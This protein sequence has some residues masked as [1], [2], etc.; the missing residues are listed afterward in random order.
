MLKVLK[1]LNYTA[2]RELDME[3]LISAIASW[4][5]CKVLDAGINIAQKYLN[6]KKKNTINYPEEVEKK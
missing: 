5:V 4:M 1:S 2:L 6:R 3:Y